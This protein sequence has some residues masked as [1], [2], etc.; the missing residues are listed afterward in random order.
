MDELNNSVTRQIGLS[1]VIAIKRKQ[2]YVKSAM[3][4]NGPIGFD[5]KRLPHDVKVRYLLE[6]SDLKGKRRHAGDMN[7]SPQIYYIRKSLIQK[8]QPILYWIVDDNG[9][10]PERSFV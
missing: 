2:V 10:G 3:S 1:P 4:R 6:S 7:W 8:N 5:E 9:N